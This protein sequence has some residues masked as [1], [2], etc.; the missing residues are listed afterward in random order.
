MI[1]PGAKAQFPT[2]SVHLGLVNSHIVGESDSWKPAFGTQAGFALELPFECD[3]PL[4]AWT[5]INISMQ[6]ARWEEDWG[7]G[8]TKGITRTLNLNIPLTARYTFDFGLYLEAGIQPGLMLIAKD[9]Y[10]GEAYSVKD[11]FKTF[12]LGVLWGVGYNF[13][14]NFGLKFRVIPGVTNINAGDYENIKDRNLIFALLGTYTLPRK[15]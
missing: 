12:D 2:F 6:G 4:R 13:E 5:E 15:Q 3:F 7:E 10:D 1:H 9:R 11:W 14:N 8:L